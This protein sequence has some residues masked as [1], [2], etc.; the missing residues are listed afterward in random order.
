MVAFD[1]ERAAPQR[2]HGC[3]TEILVNSERSNGVR[4]R[5]NGHIAKARLVPY[6]V[7]VPSEANSG[8]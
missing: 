5:D 1:G 2:G 7:T 4:V 6:A 3:R 8:A